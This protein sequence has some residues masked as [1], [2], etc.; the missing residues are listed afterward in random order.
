MPALRAAA[1]SQRGLR[2]LQPCSCLAEGRSLLVADLDTPISFVLLNSPVVL[3]VRT[4][5]A[6]LR[7]A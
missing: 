7:R 3:M 1:P 6:D 4:G 5:S 2:T